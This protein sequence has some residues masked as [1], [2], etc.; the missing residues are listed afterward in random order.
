MEENEKILAHIV[1]CIRETGS[2][3]R[4]QIRGYITSGDE[5]YITRN[6]EARRLI[7]N[8]EVAR[9][10]QYLGQESEC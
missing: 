10:E 1:K 5:R 8:I 2:D 7:G 3:P 6:G 4:D 9:L